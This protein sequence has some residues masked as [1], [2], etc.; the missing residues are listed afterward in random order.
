MYRF[1]VLTGNCL[2]ARHID[3]QATEVACAS[4]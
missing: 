3:A 4:A 1:K 2:C